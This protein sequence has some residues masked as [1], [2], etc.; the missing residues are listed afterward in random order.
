VQ[1][2]LTVLSG[3]SYVASWEVAGH[4]NGL[5]GGGILS[6]RGAEVSSGHRVRLAVCVSGGLKSRSVR[7]HGRISNRGGRP[8]WPQA[9]HGM[10]QSTRAR[11]RK[12][13]TATMDLQPAPGVLRRTGGPPRG[14]VCRVCGAP[15]GRTQGER[16]PRGAGRPKL[17]QGR[18]CTLAAQAVGCQP[19]IAR[20]VRAT[21][22][23]RETNDPGRPGRVRREGRGTIRWHWQTK[24]RAPARTHS[25]LQPPEG[26]E[27]RSVSEIP[28]EARPGGGAGSSTPERRQHTRRRTGA[29]CHSA[30]RLNRSPSGGRPRAQRSVR[31][32]REPASTGGS[33]GQGPWRKTPRPP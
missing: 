27:E 14:G 28:P 13:E 4:G 22:W 18:A 23:R 25:D 11:R 16:S 21:R 24:G 2:P 29:A 8:H 15:P 5:R 3:E 20:G 7:G 12:L 19:R 32:G 9:A 33:G 1:Y 31:P 17:G 26:R 30:G 10:E 6:E